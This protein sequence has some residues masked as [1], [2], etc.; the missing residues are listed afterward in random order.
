MDYQTKKNECSTDGG[1]LFLP[2]CWCQESQYL[3]ILFHMSQ[4]ESCWIHWY[5]NVRKMTIRKSF[6]R[7]MLSWRGFWTETILLWGL[8]R[9]LVLAYPLTFTRTLTTDKGNFSLIFPYFECLNLNFLLISTIQLVVSFA[10][11]NYW[12]HF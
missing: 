2:I 7:V 5:C 4:A 12:W 3:F 11:P 10:Y 1:S 8:S 6:S 9:S